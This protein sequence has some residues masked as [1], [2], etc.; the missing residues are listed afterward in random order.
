MTK[1][2]FSSWADTFDISVEE[3]VS[4][5]AAGG[6][7]HCLA[8]TIFDTDD[9]AEVAKPTAVMDLCCDASGAFDAG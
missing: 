2:L 1:A 4:G 7:R 5:R 9:E 3:T 8:K 6:Q